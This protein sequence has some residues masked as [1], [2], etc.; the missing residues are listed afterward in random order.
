[1][2]KKFL[3]T[4]AV[5]LALGGVAQAQTPPDVLAS[6]KSYRT[7]L[8]AK[9]YAAAMEHAYAA[10]QLGEDKMGDHKTTGDL[11]KNYADIATRQKSKEKDVKTAYLRS[12][13]LASLHTDNP[14][15]TQLSR[16]VSYGEWAMKI[17]KING[18]SR[19]LKN[20][21]ALA[22]ENGFDRS[23]YL[24]EIY[25]M[26]A[27]LY[28]SRSNHDKVEDYSAKAL[29]IF[30]NPSD[31][32]VTYHPYMA[33]L[34]LGYGK[35][36]KD[37]ILPAALAYQTVMENIDGKLPEKHPF[38]MKAMG[39]WMSM[40]DRLNRNGM[41]E[42]AEAAGLC[43]CWPYDKKRNDAVRAVERVPP[44]MPRKA[45]QS[46]FSIVEFDLAD[47]GSVMNPRLLESW[48]EEIWDKSSIAA[49][50]KWKYTPRTADETDSD[51]TDIIT[52]LRY[53][54]TGPNGKIIE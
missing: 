6:Y 25:T 41:L 3:M 11:A 38:V 44:K 34:Y 18:L 46:G 42:E 8:E 36:G 48:P 4:G 21:A 24:G 30:E 37:D 17:D 23:I 39:R 53:R 27:S 52:T 47:D 12:I 45:W 5:M 22:E 35:E 15:E 43:Q 13:D 28:V 1:M 26:L 14:V 51:R 50:K 7:A 20:A 19:R 40:R 33:Q 16:E 49:V 31:D 10:W 2:F 29:A 32:Y 9:N 54:L